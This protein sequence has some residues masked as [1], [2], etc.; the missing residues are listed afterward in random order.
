MKTMN[1]LIILK[2]VNFELIYL[3]SIRF[4]KIGINRGSYTITFNIFL[5][6]CKLQT[7]NCFFIQCFI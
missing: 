7:T 4:E 1:E 5:S 2:A 6:I 3:I